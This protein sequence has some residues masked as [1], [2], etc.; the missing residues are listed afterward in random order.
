MNIYVGNLDYRVNENDL[1]D[2]FQEYGTV[3][4]SK[5]ITDKYNGRSKGFGFITM[6]SNDEANK[7]ISE[8]NGTSYEDRDIVV[9]EARPRKTNYND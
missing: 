4:S 8:L 3:S 5:I 1:E 2:L 7:A 9:N 6:E